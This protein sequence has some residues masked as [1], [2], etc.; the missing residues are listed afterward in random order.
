MK[1]FWY[2][3]RPY[4]EYTYMQ[5]KYWKNEEDGA[6]WDNIRYPWWAFIAD[7]IRRR[8]YQLEM[9]GHCI[10]RKEG[11]VQ[12]DDDN[13]FGH[14]PRWIPAIWYTFKAIVC[15]LLF[16]R[17]TPKPKPGRLSLDFDWV[18]VGGWGLG[19]DYWGEACGQLLR[20]GRGILRNWYV[21]ESGV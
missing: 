6:S 12:W 4:G 2:A 8:V 9:I 5:P 18:D 7:F 20:V 21:E 13:L 17:R 3:C 1:D 15:I 11:W 14:C 19:L 10:N 16:H